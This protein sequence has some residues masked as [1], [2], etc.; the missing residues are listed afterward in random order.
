LS[1][2]PVADTSELDLF[3]KLLTLRTKSE[4]QAF[5]KATTFTQRGFA[6][7]ILATEGGAFP[8][9]HLMHVDDRV[10]EHLHLTEADKTAMKNAKAGT[11]TKGTKKATN[12]ILQFFDE[13][14]YLVGHLFGN[15]DLTDWHLFFFDQRDR[16]DHRNHWEHGPH[17][18][19]VSV[20]WP[21]LEPGPV[22]ESFR[23]N[24]ET[25]KGAAHLRYQTPD[26][27]ARRSRTF[28]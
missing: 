14:R 9:V 6:D 7:L 24:R 22:W 15:D 13:R 18:H 12:K 23:V 11:H 19:Y 26:P 5:A 28:Q 4:V 16:D 3:L 20:L 8:W 10:P 21:N 2:A 17:I 27:P 1:A 25:P